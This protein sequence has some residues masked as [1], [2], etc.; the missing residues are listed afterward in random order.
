MKAKE[1]FHKYHEALKDYTSNTSMRDLVLELDAETKDI[2][3]KRHAQTNG[4]IIAVIKEQNTKWNKIASIYEQTEGV[5]L[6]KRD[7]YLNLL[8]DRM[9][10]LATYISM[11][12]QVRAF[13]KEHP[14]VG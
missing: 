6:L 12:K 9:P 8:K 11:E 13:M 4:A 7:G 14:D 5:D 3:N 1:Y 2:I 10:Q